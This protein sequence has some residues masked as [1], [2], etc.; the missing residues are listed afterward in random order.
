MKMQRENQCIMLFK[1]E[2][3]DLLLL[4]TK[5]NTNILRVDVAFSAQIISGNYLRF[6]GVTFRHLL[7][8]TTT[9]KCSLKKADPKF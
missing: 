2:W 5:E 3:C 4:D 6:L 1:W 9:G 8:E 7:V